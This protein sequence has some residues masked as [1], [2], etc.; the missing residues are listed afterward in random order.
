VVV[1]FWLCSVSPG[2]GFEVKRFDISRGG[3]CD[4]NQQMFGWLTVFADIRPLRRI[5]SERRQ[6]WK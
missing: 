2:D 3:M 1:R 5:S 6:R 4:G